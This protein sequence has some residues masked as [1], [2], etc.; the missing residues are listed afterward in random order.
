MQIIE[1]FSYIFGQEKIEYDTSEL[2]KEK[3][4]ANSSKQGEAPRLEA[5]RILEKYPDIKDRI[6]ESFNNFIKEAFLWETE[7]RVT[8]SWLTK[9]GKGESVHPHNHLNSFYSGLLYFDN[10]TDEDCELRF[11]NP[12]KDSMPIAL[13]SSK[14]PNAM[15]KD[16][17]IRPENNL[18]VFFPSWITH[19]SLPNESKERRSLA[20]NFMPRDSYGFSDSYFDPRWNIH[21]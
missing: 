4:I 14:K 13:G 21:T 12:I 11:Q 9:L 15:T 3:L 6:N 17:G 16:I 18:I 19:Y 8:T 20:F 5:F 2:K 7:F 1:P 10:Y